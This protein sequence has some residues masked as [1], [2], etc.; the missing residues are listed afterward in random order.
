[1]KIIIPYLS[2]FPMFGMNTIIFQLRKDY[3]Y[4]CL[5]FIDLRLLKMSWNFVHLKNNS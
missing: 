5:V 4:L 2:K 1:M 3:L